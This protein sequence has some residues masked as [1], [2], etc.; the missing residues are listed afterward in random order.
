MNWGFNWRFDALALA[1]AACLSVGLLRAEDQLVPGSRGVIHFAESPMQSADA[2]Q[3]RARLSALEDPP[4]YDVTKEEFEVLLPPDYQAG[5]SYGLF[6]WISAGD[7]PSIGK[8][9]EAELAKRD[10]IFAGARNSGNKRNIFD[11][12][13][14]AIDANHNMRQR[15]P[16][17]GRRVYVS[18]F[19]GG[20]RVASMVG[21][22]WAEMFSGTICFMGVNFYTDITGEDGKLYTLNYSPDD[23]VVGLAKRYCRYVLVTAERDFNLANTRGV[24]KDGFQAEGFQRSLLLEVPNH[25]HSPPSAEWLAKALDFVDEGRREAAK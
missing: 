2:E 24:W 16:I 5:K 25:G 9:W 22:C 11:R 18:G 23:E 21:V 10:I 4:P 17:D 8:D 20:S 19:S 12:M 1:I 6:I 13:R 3:V 7:M 15:Y 14:M